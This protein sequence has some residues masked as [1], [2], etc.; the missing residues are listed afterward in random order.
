M[1]ELKRFF[2]VPK[3]LAHFKFFKRG[4]AVPLATWQYAPGQLAPFFLE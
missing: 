3:H 2:A 1:R 4:N